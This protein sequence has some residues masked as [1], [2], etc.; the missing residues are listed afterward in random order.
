M[1][2]LSYHIIS[3]RI[4]CWHVNCNFSFVQPDWNALGGRKGEHTSHNAMQTRKLR[5][6][7]SR[8]DKNKKGEMINSHIWHIWLIVLRCTFELLETQSHPCLCFVIGHWSDFI[9]CNGRRGCEHYLLNT[10]ACHI[11]EAAASGFQLLVH[12]SAYDWSLHKVTHRGALTLVFIESAQTKP[13]FSLDRTDWKSRFIQ[14]HKT[15]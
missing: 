4:T 14:S 13:S 11:A 12:A 7:I 5:Q 3:R 6:S 10:A 2:I 1:M 9:R 15:F 8:Q